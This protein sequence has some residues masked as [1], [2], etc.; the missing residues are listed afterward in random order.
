MINFIQL[1]S[2]LT[3]NGHYKWFYFDTPLLEH[4]TAEEKLQV[5]IETIDP[6]FCRIFYP[7]ENYK[8]REWIK[9]TVSV[10]DERKVALQKALKKALSE[11]D[12]DEIE[13]I[14]QRMKDANRN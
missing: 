4:L 10:I 9:A 2:L 7:K 12:F 3:H 8:P 6:L 1:C 5:H 13:K 11:F 14:K